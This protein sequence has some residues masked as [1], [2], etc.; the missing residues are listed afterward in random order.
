MN[1]VDGAVRTVSKNLVF[2]LLGGAVQFL[3]VII[4]T[5]LVLHQIGADSF[6]ILALVGGTTGYFVYLDIGMGETVIKK[7]SETRDPEKLGTVVSTLFCFSAGF[8]VVVAL[9]TA[10][11]ALFGVPALFSFSPEHLRSAVR[12]F[13]VIAGGVWVLYPLNVFSKVFIGLNRMDIYNAQRVVFQTLILALV[14]G[15][16]RVHA[17]AE[18]AVAAI[19][20]GGLMWKLSSFVLVRKLYPGIRISPALFDR[21]LLK[22]FLRYKSYATVSQVSGHTVYQCDIYMIGILLN[23]AQVALYSIANVIAMKIS[24]VTGIFSAVLFP[25][26]SGF[27]GANLHGAI[28]KSFLLGTKVVAVALM[29]A[30]VFIWAYAD[31]LIQ[32]W[33]GPEYLS[34]SPALKVLSAAWYINSLSSVATLTV[35][36]VDRPDIEARIGLMVASVN[37]MLDYFFI[38]KW[39][40]AGAVYATLA[41]Q[42][43]GVATL[44]GVLL[45]RF[46]ANAMAFFGRLAALAAAGAATG[47]VYLPRVSPWFAPLQAALQSALFFAVCYVIAFSKEERGYIRNMAAIVMKKEGA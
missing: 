36:A 3:L 8:G 11:F 21:A 40:F 22:D 20:V 33:V 15:A 32:L 14:L 41:A 13:L 31:L 27:H 37:I 29:P 45:K 43:L 1:I 18:S 4:G 23:P 2:N 9:L 25:S 24:E 7:V 39:G 34:T 44:I 10:L 26:I 17:S 6:G 28:R 38:L 5:R 30:V 16:L 35:K 47:A 12:V 19:T 46:G 42:V